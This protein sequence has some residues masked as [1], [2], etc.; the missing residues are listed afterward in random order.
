VA[1]SARNTAE[2]TAQNRLK[3][4]VFYKDIWQYPGKPFSFCNKA[5]T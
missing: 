2:I 1:Q 4:F 5:Q 3:L